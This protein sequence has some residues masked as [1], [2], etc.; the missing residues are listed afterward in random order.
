[1]LVER[2]VDQLAATGALDNTVLIFTSDNGFFHGQHRIQVGKGLPYEEASHVPLLIRGGG[3]PKDKTASQFVSNV[4][5]APTI[6]AITEAN[7]RLVM[8][9]RSLLPLAQDP[10]LATARDLLI[11]NVYYG[12]VRNKSFLYVEHNTGEQ[13]LYDMR[14]GSANYDPYQL[15]SRHAD[16][17][18]SEIMAELANK[19]N[20][21]RDCSGESCEVQ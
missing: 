16:S 7:A 10:G 14:P 9:G 18:Y 3:F 19:L 5:L 20:E 11:E 4:D 1:D 13:E 6:V 21:L 12:A 15:E 17:A 8:D 2:V